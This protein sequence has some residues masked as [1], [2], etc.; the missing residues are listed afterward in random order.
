MFSLGFKFFEKISIE[1]LSFGHSALDFVDYFI[2][3]EVFW[4]EMSI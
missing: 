3:I 1:I 2:L 4:G